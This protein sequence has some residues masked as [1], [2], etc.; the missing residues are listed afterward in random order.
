[1][2]TSIRISQTAEHLIPDLEP[3]HGCSHFTYF[4]AEIETNLVWEPAPLVFRHST[5]S[6]Y[7]RRALH[8]LR[9]AAG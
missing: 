6:D 7:E 2:N 9:Q 1:M 8:Q 3:C 5:E 4:S